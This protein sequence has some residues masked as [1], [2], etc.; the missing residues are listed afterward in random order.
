[1]IHSRGYK[2]LKIETRI[3]EGERHAGTKPELF[4]RGLRFLFSEE[5]TH[6]LGDRREM[7]NHTQAQARVSTA[8][9]F[10]VSV[11]SIAVVSRPSRNLT[12]QLPTIR[13]A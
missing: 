7:S 2:G 11:G 1:V 8:P 10:L 6:W 4:N 5:G 12:S 13:S 9:S 3:I